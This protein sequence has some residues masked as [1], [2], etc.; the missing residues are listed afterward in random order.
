MDNKTGQSM[1]LYNTENAGFLPSKSNLTTYRRRNDQRHSSVIVQQK[2]KD[3]KLA[4]WTIDTNINKAFAK[5][6]DNHG[7]ANKDNN[8]KKPAQVNI[9]YILQYAVMD[10]KGVP[11]Y[12]FVNQSPE[13]D[14]AQN[15]L[16]NIRVKSR[17][18]EKEMTNKVISA[19]L[20]GK[21]KAKTKN[22]KN[23]N[24]TFWNVI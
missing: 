21:Y 11:K 14:K 16:T 9:E 17:E 6:D 8:T 3:A 12:H 4:D 10:S 7:L 20:I 24:N 5:N 18:P 1:E 13:T 23:N 19:K 22:F 2:N 15:P